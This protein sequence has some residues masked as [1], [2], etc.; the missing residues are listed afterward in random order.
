MPEC[1]PAMADLLVAALCTDQR[2]AVP[3]A[4]EA[5]RRKAAAQ[6][7]A[8]PAKSDRVF[9]RTDSLPWSKSAV[10]DHFARSLA[11]AGITKPPCSTT[12]ATRSPPG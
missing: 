7:I 9:S 1:S 6:G 8:G 12:F 10:Q 2:D 5:A 3:C 4:G 11:A